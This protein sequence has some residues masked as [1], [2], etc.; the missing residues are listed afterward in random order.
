MDEKNKELM[1]HMKD[2]LPKKRYIHTLGVA[3]LS[4]ALAMCYGYDNV[5]AFTAGILH[6]CAKCEPDDVILEKCISLGLSVTDDQC[7]AP[8]LLHGMLGAYYAKNIYGI[9]D[10]DILNAITWHTTGRPEMGLLEKIVF[11]ADYIET[12]RTQST[13][14]SLNEIRKIAFTDIDYAVYLETKNIVD[15]LGSTGAYID[16]TT[17]ETMNYYNRNI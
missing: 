4:S 10:A 9:K 2:V 8:Y 17:F 13:T 15:Y 5:K 11:V 7:H 1:K 14:P 6:D 16:R 12:G 3:Y